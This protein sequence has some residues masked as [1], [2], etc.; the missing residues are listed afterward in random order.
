LPSG[1]CS[2]FIPNVGSAKAAIK[3]L[4]DSD[5]TYSVA[6]ELGLSF[7]LFTNVDLNVGARY[8]RYAVPQVVLDGVHDARIEFNSADEIG[9]FAGITARF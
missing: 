6:A 3:N 4:E 9:G 1:T 5:T 8:R 7:G 2:T